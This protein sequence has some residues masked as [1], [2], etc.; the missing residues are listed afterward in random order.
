MVGK[1]NPMLNF[2]VD[3]ENWKLKLSWQ[4]EDPPGEEDLKKVFEKLK[5]EIAWG[6]AEDLEDVDL[7][8]ADQKTFERVRDFQERKKKRE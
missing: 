1:E 5:E 3:G 6:E 8:G 4:G 7:D 2:F